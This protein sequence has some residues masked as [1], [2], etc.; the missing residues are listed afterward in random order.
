M[1]PFVKILSL[2]VALPTHR[3][4][5]QIVQSY[6]QMASYPA[7]KRKIVETHPYSLSRRAHNPLDDDDDDDYD[8]VNLYSAFNYC[9]PFVCKA[10][11]YDT[12]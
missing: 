8:D 5:G 6:Y 9:K 2:L 7:D 3:R 12:C 11:G 4:S 10:F 1:P